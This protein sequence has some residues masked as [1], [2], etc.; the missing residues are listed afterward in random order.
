MLK[1][2]STLDWQKQQQS[3]DDLTTCGDPAHLASR[4]NWISTLPL[5]S[6]QPYTPGRPGRVQLEYVKSWT[7]STSA[8]FTEDLGHYVEGPCDE[9]EGAKPD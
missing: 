9:Y 7:S 6:L 4:L 2:I 5:S 1:Q 3:F 8:I